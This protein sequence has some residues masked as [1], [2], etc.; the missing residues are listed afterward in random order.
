MAV[1]TAFV[2]H[3]NTTF[4]ADRAQLAPLYQD[5]SMLTFEG[6]QIQGQAAI[7]EHLAT[8][9]TFQTSQTHVTTMDAQPTNGG[10]LVYVTGNIVVDGDAE[11][12]LKY[13]HIFHLLPAGEAFWVQND[14]F[15]LTYF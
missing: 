4:D 1:A 7:I 6:T 14:M 10:I 5:G 12:A 13:S 2:G 11:K 3:Y 9:L 8:K 15:R